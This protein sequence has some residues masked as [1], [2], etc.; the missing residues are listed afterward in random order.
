MK[1]QMKKV[2]TIEIKQNEDGSTTITDND[3]TQLYIGFSGQES[4]VEF[5]GDDFAIIIDDLDSLEDIRESIHKLLN[6]LNPDSW[7]EADD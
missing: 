1:E 2:L 6:F 7:F 4:N 3:K 5:D